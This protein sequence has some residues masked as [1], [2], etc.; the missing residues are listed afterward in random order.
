MSYVSWHTYG[1]GIR[2]SDINVAS[3]ESLK[4]LIHMA[5][6]YEKAV[7][8]W[9]AD[10]EITDPSVDDYLDFDQDYCMGLASMLKE[11]IE[12]AEKVRFTACDDCYS[13]LFLVYEPKYPWYLPETER[14]LDEESIADILRKYV[15]IIT[16]EEIAID[17]YSA[18]N[19]G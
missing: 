7:N 19:G 9:I 6:E 18:E 16:D 15:S 4:E 3:V 13:N 1:Y 14:S 17:Y 10:S 5:P 11:I 12:E 2:V 8:E